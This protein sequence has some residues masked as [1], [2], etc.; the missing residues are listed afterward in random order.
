MRL[1]P[2]AHSQIFQREERP[3]IEND[4]LVV[5]GVVPHPVQSNDVVGRP[6]HAVHDVDDFEPHGLSS[7]R[8][9]LQDGQRSHRFRMGGLHGLPVF[10]DFISWDFTAVGQALNRDVN[11]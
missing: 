1:L 5:Q 6:V 8:I 4:V 10:T 9:R 2:P 7:K 11:E 3:S